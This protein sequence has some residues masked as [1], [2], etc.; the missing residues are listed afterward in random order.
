MVAKVLAEAARL[1]AEANKGYSLADLERACMEAQIPSQIV[2][3]AI[4]NIEQ[5]RSGSRKQ[6]KRG[7]FIGIILLIPAIAS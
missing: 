4:R 6:I 1:H 7:T 3:E 5:K 2:W